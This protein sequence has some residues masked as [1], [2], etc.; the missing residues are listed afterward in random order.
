MA[1]N[2]VLY[3]LSCPLTRALV[4]NSQSNVYSVPANVSLSADTPVRSKKPTDDGT[5]VAGDEGSM[6]PM[7][8]LVIPICEG[9]VGSMFGMRVIGWRLFPGTN[10]KPPVWIQDLLFDGFC[11]AGFMVGP[12]A[13]SAIGSYALS[14]N[15]RLCDKV[16]VSLQGVQLFQFDFMNPTTEVIIGMNALWARA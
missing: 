5:F 9:T 16:Y 2:V 6:A 10:Q 8:I 3:N 1:T 15:E 12:P 11:M 7:S 4:E 14:E 13:A